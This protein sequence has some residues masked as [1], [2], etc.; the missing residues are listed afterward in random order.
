[1]SIRRY[2]YLY[3]QTVDCVNYSVHNMLDVRTANGGLSIIII[4][5]NV[6]V[7]S[8]TTEIV[9]KIVQG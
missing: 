2:T 5:Y 1:M 9:K 3:E 7:G 4:L 8:N 6:K